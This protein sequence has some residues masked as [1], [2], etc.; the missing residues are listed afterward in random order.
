MTQVIHVSHVQGVGVDTCGTCIT[1]VRAKVV[2]IFRFQIVVQGG[3][4]FPIP[5]STQVIPVSHVHGSGVDTSDT[6]I[7]CVRAKVVFIF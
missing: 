5:K 6:C 3:V 1:G 2:C 4:Y 7:T